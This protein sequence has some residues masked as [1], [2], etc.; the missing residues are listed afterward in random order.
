[1]FTLMIMSTLNEN[2]PK[3]FQIKFEEN[4]THNTHNLYSSGSHMPYCEY[5]IISGD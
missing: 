1:M 3:N 4:Y 2:Q 5:V